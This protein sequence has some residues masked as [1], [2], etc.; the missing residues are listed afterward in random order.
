MSL[1]FTWLP[2]E[3]AVAR[4]LAAIER[5]LA[6][7]DPRPHWGKVFTLPARTIR[8][9]YPR[10]TDFLQLAERHDPTGTF[11]NPFLAHTLGLA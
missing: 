1:H 8:A 10:A 2:D 7:F 11:G 9:S 3:A 5:Q 4:A 6:P